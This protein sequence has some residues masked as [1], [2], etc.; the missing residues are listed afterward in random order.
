M[1]DAWL[2]IG[3]YVLIPEY[4][5]ICASYASKVLAGEAALPLPK[6]KEHTYTAGEVGKML[7]GISANKIGRLVNKHNLKT[8]EYGEIR[9]VEINGEP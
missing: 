4:K 9:V 3:E 1:A 2:R 6:V 5:Q 8:S 7:G